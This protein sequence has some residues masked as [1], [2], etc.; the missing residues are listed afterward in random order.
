MY[1]QKAI[2]KIT[3]KIPLKIYSDIWLHKPWFIK[4][5][6]KK[7]QQTYKFDSVILNY[8][9][10]SKIANYF[11]G[12]TILFTHDVF[13]FRNPRLIGYYWISCTP[14]EEAKCINRVNYVLAIHR[15]SAIHLN[16][17]MCPPKYNPSERCQSFHLLYILT[18]NLWI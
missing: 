13:S 10:L 18:M 9:W 14:N 1:I 7:I 15:K 16:K 11:K 6:I 3:R 4:A 2:F 17:L 5:Y 8:I 12:N